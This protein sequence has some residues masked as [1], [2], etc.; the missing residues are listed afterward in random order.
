[1]DPVSLILGALAAGAAGGAVEG[2]RESASTAARGAYD[3]LRAALAGRFGGDRRA[4]R[5]LARYEADPRDPAVRDALDAE[6]TRT[7]AAEDPEVL[8]AAA[9]LVRLSA[10]S[11]VV[12]KYGLQVD[13]DVHG[14]AQGDQQHVTMHF[15]TPPPGTP[16]RGE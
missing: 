16:P 10:G 4:E 9:A 12:Q 13:G 7:G 11:R 15:G 8:D 1:M 5:A 14:L 3:R 6:L 2:V